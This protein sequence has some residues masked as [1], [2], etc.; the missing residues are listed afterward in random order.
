LNHALNLPRAVDRIGQRDH[1]IHRSTRNGRYIN[2][3]AVYLI[4]MMAFSHFADQLVAH[5]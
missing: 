3:F 1:L 2:I 5:A 4:E